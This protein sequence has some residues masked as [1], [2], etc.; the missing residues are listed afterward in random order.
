MTSRHLL[1]RVVRDALRGMP[2]PVDGG[3]TRV[4]PWRADVHGV[5]A[6]T[7]HA[8]VVAPGAFTD[9]DLDALGVDGFG[10]AHRPEIAV[11]LA[12][13]H[14]IDDLDMLLAAWGTAP[15]PSE[16]VERPDLQRHSRAERA[17][18]MRD[19]VRTFGFPDRADVVVVLA[20]GIG[21]LTE[22][23]LEV[24]ETARGAHLGRRALLGA[25]ALVPP[26][27]VLVASVSPGNVASARTF[28]A[29]GFDLVGSVQLIHP[30]H[31]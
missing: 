9:D 25:R 23:S 29:A 30:P 19:G 17:R 27:D 12:G 10:G 20:R 14:R 7:G 1:A 28:A 24:D 4:P 18:W 5:V 8:F 13:T 6:M 31:S 22:V 15:D 26:D 2:P 16:L 11:R 21:G 3:W